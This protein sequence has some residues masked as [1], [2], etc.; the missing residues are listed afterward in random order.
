MIKKLGLFSF[1]LSIG[2]FVDLRAAAYFDNFNLSNIP[3]SQTQLFSEHQ[4][5][6]L[7]LVLSGGGAKA[8]A[9]VGVLEELENLNIKPSMIIGVS[10]GAIV[11]SLYANGLTAS[12][13]KELLIDANSKDFIDYS[14]TDLPTNLS[15]NKKLKKFLSSNL[16]N[17]NIEDLQIPFVAVATNL[18]TG[19]Q[20]PLSKGDA[21]TMVVASSAYPGIFKPVKIG[22]NV[23]TDGGV[24]GNLPIRLAQKFNPKKILGVNIGFGID[25]KIPENAL[26]ILLKSVQIMQKSYDDLSKQ[27]SDFTLDIDLH[28]FSSFDEKRNEDAYKK[29]KEA[30]LENKTNILNMLGS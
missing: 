23:Y 14:I 3:E 16:D 6:E 10:S 11:G 2:F 13:I 17:K 9:H 12:E 8:L 26:G 20:V 19:E 30:V 7:I 5:T 29:G 27:Y 15:S 1:V 18:K 4:E 25:D 24:A 28:E 21:A 22:D